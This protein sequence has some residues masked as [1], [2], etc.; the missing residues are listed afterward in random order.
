MTVLLRR[1]MYHCMIRQGKNAADS[2]GWIQGL[3]YCIIVLYS[4]RKPT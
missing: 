3:V 2:S 4:N 1:E